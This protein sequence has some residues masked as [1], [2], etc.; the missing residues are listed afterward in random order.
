M[1]DLSC[2]QIPGDCDFDGSEL[3]YGP[4]PV[5]D[6]TPM[7]QPTMLTTPTPPRCT[8]PLEATPTLQPINSNVPD[9]HCT[10][11]YNVMNV[12]QY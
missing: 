2:H 3:S 11:R 12:L 7:P 9:H 1:Y 10:P 6:G 4:I 8:F 5:L